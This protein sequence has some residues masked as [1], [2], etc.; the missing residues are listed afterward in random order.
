MDIIG[1]IKAMARKNPKRIVMPEGDESRIIKAAG[2]LSREGCA[3]VILLGDESKIRRASEEGLAGV[4]IVDPRCDDR[5]RVFAQR[6]V[7]IRKHESIAMDEAERLMSDPIHFGIMMLQ[8]DADGFLAGAKHATA[9]TVRPALQI[10]KTAP[11]VGTISSFFIMVVPDC[12]YGEKGV[13]VFADCA[14]NPNPPAFKLADIAVST[15]RMAER[16][17]GIKPRVAMLSFSTKGSARHKL[18]DKVTE[19]TRIAK[20]KA[21]DIE[22]DGELQ[23]DAAL[24]P[25]VGMKK[26]PG[27]KVAGAANVL[28]FPDLQSANIAYKLVQRLARAK[29]IGPIL[30]G[31]NKPVNDLS[32]G[33]SV[34]DIVNIAAVTVIQCGLLSSP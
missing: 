32:R 23:V 4:E 6:Y 12:E 20:E 31:L 15:A 25:S 7:E 27:S 3:R 13:M 10:I 9:E 1:K 17:C 29:A 30:Q 26:A 24:A 5:K 33:C 18:V 8:G 21:P 28:I 14:I 19:A 22:I 34:D 16:L 11:G 2:I